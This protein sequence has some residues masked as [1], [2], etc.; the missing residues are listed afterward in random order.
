[1]QSELAFRQVRRDALRN[2]LQFSTETSTTGTGGVDL[3]A[4]IEELARS[5][6]AGSE[7]SG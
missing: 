2:I 5:V 7:R 1:M 6:P 4:Q 3:R